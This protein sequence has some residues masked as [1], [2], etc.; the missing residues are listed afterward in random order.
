MD[1]ISKRGLPWSGPAAKIKKIKNKNK[2]FFSLFSFQRTYF[3]K[4]IPVAAL[5]VPAPGT[6]GELEL[7]F[8]DHT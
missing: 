1:V 3:W 2:I 8:I 4:I 6:S 7:D 5:A